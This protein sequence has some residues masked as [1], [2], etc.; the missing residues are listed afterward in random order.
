MSN[1]CGRGSTRPPRSWHPLPSPSLPMLRLVPL[2]NGRARQAPA[3]TPCRSTRSRSSRAPA[4]C[5]GAPPVH[6]V[7]RPGRAETRWA[8][9]Q[10]V[11]R[12]KSTFRAD[13]TS[14]WADIRATLTDTEMLGESTDLSITVSV[15]DSVLACSPNCGLRRMRQTKHSKT[16]RTQVSAA[17]NLEAS[18]KV[19][20]LAAIADPSFGCECMRDALPG[21]AMKT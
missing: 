17:P 5:S 8:F 11:G 19:P 7:R 20:A 2:H 12:P 14:R 3:W 1:P 10:V 21:A 16:W 18:G 13:T 4:M 9:R 15:A 6:R